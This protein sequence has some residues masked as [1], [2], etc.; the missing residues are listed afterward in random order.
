ME[1]CPNGDLF[2]MVKRTGKFSSNLSKYFFHQILDA[3]EY[4]HSS[5]GLAHLDLKLENILISKD[6][7]IK[8]C[9]FG[10]VEELRSKVQKGKGTDGYKAPEI[11]ECD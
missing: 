4:L 5:R 2:D 11:Y 7:K 6:L 9:D 1:Y 3:L 8:L 10:F